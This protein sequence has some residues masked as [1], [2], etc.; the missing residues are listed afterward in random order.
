MRSEQA[1]TI[2]MDS[3]LALLDL[4]PANSVLSMRYIPLCGRIGEAEFPVPS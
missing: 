3:C 1:K 2:L 4:E